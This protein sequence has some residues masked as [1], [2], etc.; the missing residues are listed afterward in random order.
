VVVGDSSIVVVV[1]EI[2]VVG[3]PTVGVGGRE[4]VGTEARVVVALVV[5]GSSGG[6]VSSGSVGGVAGTNRRTVVVGAAVVAGACV[7]EVE[8]TAVVGPPSTLDGGREVVEVS[9][10]PGRGAVTGAWLAASVR[11]SVCAC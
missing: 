11:T 10:G 7:V 3:S 4:L 5:V 8:V 1:V 6:V 2:V 9:D